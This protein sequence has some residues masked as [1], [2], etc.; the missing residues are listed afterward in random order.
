M[1]LQKYKKLV[2]QPNRTRT[3]VITRLIVSIT[4]SKSNSIFFHTRI[5]QNSRAKNIEKKYR[6]NTY[7]QRKSTDKRISP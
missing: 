1:Q 3:Y 4:F 7:Y 2:I 5:R 6:K